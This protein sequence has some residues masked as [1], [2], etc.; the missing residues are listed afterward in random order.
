MLLR[1][2]GKDPNEKAKGV[3]VDEKGILKT[4]TLGLGIISDVTST[5]NT[6]LA[7][8]FYGNGYGSNTFSNPLY[9]GELKDI[10]IFIENETGVD[11]RFRSYQFFPFSNSIPESVEMLGEIQMED[12]LIEAGTAKWVNF[13]DYILLK[14]VPLPYLTIQLR[15]LNGSLVPEE[16]IGDVRVMFVGRRI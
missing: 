14:E 2:A 16:K 9:V 6:N 3:A 7:S 8:I 15:T 13:I 10:S 5:W 11:I 4:K 12:I 1:M